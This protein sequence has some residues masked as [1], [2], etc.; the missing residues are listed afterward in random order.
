M[1]VAAILARKGRDV[2]TVPKETSVAEVVAILAERRIGAV[3]VADDFQRIL[4]IVSE[5]DVVRMLAQAGTDGL[6]ASVASIMTAKVITCSDQDTINDVMER[7][8]HGRFRHLPVVEDGRLAGIISIGDVVK[9][10]IEQVEREA[11]EMRA[12]IAMA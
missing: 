1:T 10:R 4:G 2:L 5:R 6:V 8:T 9:A 7:M 12:Y 11:D 3:V